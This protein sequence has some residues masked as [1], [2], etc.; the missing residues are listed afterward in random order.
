MDYKFKQIEEK[1][2]KAWSDTEIYKVG[3]DPNKKKFY[4]LDMFP[5]PSGAGLHVGHPLGYIASDIIARYKRLNGYNVLHPMGYD[6]FGLPAEQYAIES[7]QHPAI[8]TKKNI[9]K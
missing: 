2:S 4:V 1:W 7:G 5:Y 9:S 3:E 8:T 6:S